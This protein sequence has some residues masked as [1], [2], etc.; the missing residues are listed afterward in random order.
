MFFLTASLLLHP[1]RF[2]G[3]IIRLWIIRTTKRV[4][5]GPTFKQVNLQQTNVIII[6]R[7]QEIVP[8]R[9]PVSLGIYVLI[10]PF[11]AASLRV[12]AL[13]FMPDLGG[14]YLCTVSPVSV[15]EWVHTSLFTSNKVIIQ[16]KQK[17]GNR[18]SYRWLQLWSFL[19]CS[20]VF[21]K[22]LCLHLY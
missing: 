10:P 6:Q 19:S 3:V 15:L 13:R 4:M 2:Y 22:N 12:W 8:G 14:C 17:S 21:F 18:T 16:C 7:P 20:K 11:I 1:G 9:S 5:I